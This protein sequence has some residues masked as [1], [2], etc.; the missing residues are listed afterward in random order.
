M[1]LFNVQQKVFHFSWFFFRL[2]FIPYRD[3][4]ELLFIIDT[5]RRHTHTTLLCWDR[6]KKRNTSK[7]KHRLE[8]QV[9]WIPGNA[10]SPPEKGLCWETT[11]IWPKKRE[12]EEKT[13]RGALAREE[14]ERKREGI[15]NFNWFSDKVSYPEVCFKSEKWHLLRS[16][17][18]VWILLN[19]IRSETR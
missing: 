4:Q 12:W 8:F 10:V 1:S 9:Y 17:V 13:E 3:P 6:E 2:I 5:P 11:L 18:S 19:V 14:M 7:G 16:P 15:V